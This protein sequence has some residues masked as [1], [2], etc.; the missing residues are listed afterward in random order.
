M[1]HISLHPSRHA[2]SSS[3]KAFHEMSNEVRFVQASSPTTRVIPRPRSCT[4]LT[5]L[6]GSLHT[7]R[8]VSGRMTV[9]IDFDNG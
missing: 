4:D 5:S 7:S 1:T 8:R 6:R 9:L 3:V 2:E